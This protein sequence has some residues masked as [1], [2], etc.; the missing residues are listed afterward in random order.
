MV[1]I[2]RKKKESAADGHYLVHSAEDPLSALLRIKGKIHESNVL[3]PQD[4]VVVVTE[5]RRP[6]VHSHYVKM[7]FNQLPEEL[8]KKT[9]EDDLVR[10]NFLNKIKEYHCTKSR[11]NSVLS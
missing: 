3:K 10:S 1:S 2:E 5:P 9:L 7:T 6:I 11:K 4:K 8:K